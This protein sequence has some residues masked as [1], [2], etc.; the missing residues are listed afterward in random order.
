MM[1]FDIE[2]A[3]ERENWLEHKQAK[4][5]KRWQKLTSM[6]WIKRIQEPEFKESLDGMHLYH[7]EVFL[8]IL[9][10]RYKAHWKDR[11]DLFCEYMTEL[12]AEKIPNMFKF[13]D[14]LK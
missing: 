10:E 13:W 12:L 14:R 8:K 11:D 9:K 7:K 3:K 1:V 4:E 2:A 5:V 6:P